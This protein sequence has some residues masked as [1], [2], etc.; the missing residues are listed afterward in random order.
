MDKNALLELTLEQ[1][2]EAG[3][4]LSE[5]DF[6]DYLHAVKNYIASNFLGE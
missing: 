5:D 3:H 2:C 1:I 4:Y 6:A